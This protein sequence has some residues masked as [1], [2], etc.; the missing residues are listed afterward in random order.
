MTAEWQGEERRQPHE[1]PCGDLRVLEAT[2]QSHLIA[3]A[4]SREEIKGRLKNMDEKLDNLASFKWL[5]IGTATGISAF[6]SCV[7]VLVTIF[8]MWK[9]K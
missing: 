1:V 3:G 2:F 7:G 5:T 8:L 9:G 4:E 6:I